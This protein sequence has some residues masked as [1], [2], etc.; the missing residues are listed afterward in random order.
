MSYWTYVNGNIVVSPMGRTQ[1]EKRYILETVLDHLPFVTGSESNMAVYIIQKDGYNSSS[2]HT[3][4]CEW[5]GYRNW[6]TLSTEMQNEYILVVNGSFRDRTF[7]E[8]Y[9]EFQKWIC[10]LAKRIIIEDVLVEIKGY[11]KSALVR[12]PELQSKQSWKTAYGQ[13]YEIPSWCQRNAEYPEPNW[14]EYLMWDT[15]KN[16]DYPM[17]L[18]YKYVNNKENDE[19]V[20]RRISYMNSHYE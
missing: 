7:D 10:R 19:E 14:C 9:K 5:G 20:E 12:N 18:T 6:K 3:E 17:L 1:A 16:S 13:M 15:A 8:T 11:E 4:F 2:S